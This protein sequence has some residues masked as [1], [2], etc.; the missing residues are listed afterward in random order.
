MAEKKKHMKK[1]FTTVVGKELDQSVKVA[2]AVKYSKW[3]RRSAKVFSKPVLISSVVVLM[4]NHRTKNC[5]DKGRE[6]A[7]RRLIKILR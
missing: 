4:T 5:L 6:L 1:T 3:K 2:T 7:S